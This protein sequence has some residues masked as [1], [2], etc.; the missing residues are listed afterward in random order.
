MIAM[1][2]LT[3]VIA[4][5]ANDQSVLDSIDPPQ[6]QK[7]FKRIEMISR[8]FT[9][10]NISFLLGLCRDGERENHLDIIDQFTTE[11]CGT[12]LLFYSKTEHGYRNHTAIDVL[13]HENGDLAGY[14]EANYSNNG[15]VTTKF[16]YSITAELKKGFQPLSLIVYVGKDKCEISWMKSDEILINGKADILAS[17]DIIPAPVD[18]KSIDFSVHLKSVKVFQKEIDKIINQV[19]WLYSDAVSHQFAKTKE[20]PLFK[21]RSNDDI[22]RCI[23]YNHQGMESL[24]ATVDVKNLFTGQQG[25]ALIVTESTPVIYY[26]GDLEFNDNMLSIKDGDIFFSKRKVPLIGNGTEVKFH[27]TGYPASYKTIV[28]NRLFGRQIEW[29]DKGE[30]IS[31][32]DLDI[33]KPWLDAPKK[34]E[35][36]EK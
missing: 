23:A 16:K 17:M 25:Y 29:N 28:R 14:E 6:S 27:P 32:I 22:I 11:Q 20:L 15:S 24:I 30:V 9:S 35:K 31:D 7:I 19:H 8:G 4:A 2:S 26:E 13:Y 5:D 36:T 3:T 33:P 18:V 34:E 10:N 21:T 12:S 1:I